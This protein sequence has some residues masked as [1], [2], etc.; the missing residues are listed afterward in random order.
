MFRVLGAGEIG[1]GLT[2]SLAMTPAASVSGFYLAHPEAAYFNVGKIGDDQLADWARRNGA[3]RRPARAA[4]WRR[5]SA[6]RQRG[7]A[8][9]IT[10]AALARCAAQASRALRCDGPASGSNAQTAAGGRLRATK[11]TLR[12]RKPSGTWNGTP[13]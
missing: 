7:G 9:T 4:H 11:A 13:G 6:E 1:M 12:Q 8:A 3:R 10:D 2:E 5:D